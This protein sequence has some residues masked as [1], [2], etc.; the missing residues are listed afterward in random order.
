MRHRIQ[1]QLDLTP[2]QSEK[3]GPIFDQAANELQQIRTETG[4]RVRQVIA[5]AERALA[6]Q[7]TP[8]QRKKLEEIEQESHAQRG[9]RNPEHRRGHREPKDKTTPGDGD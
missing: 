1:A 5:E 2:A 6:P 3:I 7:L 8:E 4:A 9:L